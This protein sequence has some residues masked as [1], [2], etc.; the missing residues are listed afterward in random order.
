MFLFSIIPRRYTYIA[1][2]EGRGYFNHHEN[3]LPAY[4][5]A[6]IAGGEGQGYFLSVK[7]VKA[8]CPVIPRH[9][10]C[11]RRRFGILQL[12]RLQSPRFLTWETP[13]GRANQPS[14]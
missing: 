3:T 11:R 6:V 7:Q 5:L 1:S 10:Y 12:V 9:S 8:P 2:G 4:S 14:G 13:N